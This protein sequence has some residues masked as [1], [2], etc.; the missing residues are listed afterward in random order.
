ML[1]SI[2]NLIPDVSYF[3]LYEVRSMEV[4]NLLIKQVRHLL[5]MVLE[6]VA[7][8]N[9]TH[10]LLMCGQYQAIA[11]TLSAEATD[12]AELQALEMYTAAAVVMLR[13]LHEQ[14]VTQCYPRVQ[15]LLSFLFK[16]TKEDIQVLHNTFHWPSAM[17]TYLHRCY[18]AQSTSKKD[19]EELLEDDQK[20]FHNEVQDLS[21]RIEI[22]AD[23]STPAEYRK[24]VDRITAIMKDLETKQIMGEDIVMREKLLN[25]TPGDTSARLEYFRDAVRPLDL[26]WNSVKVQ[27]SAVQRS[28]SSK[29]VNRWQ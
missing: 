9:R 29:P 21:R 11:D 18:G 16:M 24:S 23:I 10:M 12:C 26:L 15:F 17:Q 6:A 28:M 7:A 27:C 5:S 14:Y 8:E 20:M 22:I 4:K 13:D 1:T 19:L 25:L 2:S 3:P